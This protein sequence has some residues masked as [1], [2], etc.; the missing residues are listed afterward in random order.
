MRPD[1]PRLS[2]S[3]TL[4]ALL[5]AAAPARAQRLPTVVIGPFSTGSGPEYHWIGDALAQ[6]LTARIYAANAVN[7]LS[8]R[9]VRAAIKSDNID[10]AGL[11]DPQVASRLGTLLGADFVVVSSFTATWPDITFVVRVVDVA[12]RAVSHTYTRSGHLDELVA[13]ESD[14]A[15]QLAGFSPL[16]AIGHERGRFGT[17]NLYAWRQLMLGV[18]ILWEQSLAPGRELVLPREALSTAVQRFDQAIALDP[19]YA[20]PHA[21]KA[22]ALSLLGKDKEALAAIATALGLGLADVPEVVLAGY[23]VH[24][25]AGKQ[26]AARQILSD[27]ISAHPGFLNAR[28]YLGELLQASGQHEEA[29]AAFGQY[30]ERVPDQPYVLARMGY[31]HAKLKRY[32]QAIELSIKAV[33]RLPESPSLLL[34]LASRYI[35]AGKLMGAEETLRAA[36]DKFPEQP[37]AYV[38]LGYVYLLGNKIELAIPISEKALLVAQGADNG[39]ERAYAGLNLTRAYALQGD[40]TRAVVALRQALHDGL[41]DLGQ[42]RDDKRLAGFLARPEVKKLLAGGG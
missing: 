17:A 23:F 21:E 34:E 19:A 37:T 18:G 8:L 29:L 9:Q 35:D 32:D 39:R 33:D 11:H 38:R 4:L 31:S 20:Q 15:R 13:L 24:Y 2:A 3:L 36:I 10:R 28:S 27:A 42:L 26:P 5:V 12:R 30:L 6:A 22:V 14:L 7:Y 16:A 40:T 25:R 41:S 1:H